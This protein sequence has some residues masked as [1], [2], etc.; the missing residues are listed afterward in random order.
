M[1]LYVSVV[2]FL[3]PNS[4]QLWKYN[5]NDLFTC[6]WT[7]VMFL[8]E[9]LGFKLLHILLKKS[10]YGHPFSFLLN[11]YLGLKW[12]DHMLNSYL[13]LCET[14]YQ[15]SK[16]CTAQS[17]IFSYLLTHL[18]SNHSGNSVFR[19]VHLLSCHF[20]AFSRHFFFFNSLSNFLG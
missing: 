13:T 14:S 11:K 10:L 2:C 16:L 1:L 3:F 6:C 5:T 18:Y 9:L 20:S 8:V 17:H 12:S 15:V 7:F 19:N 4:I